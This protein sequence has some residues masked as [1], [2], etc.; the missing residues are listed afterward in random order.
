MGCLEVM[1]A[2]GHG[3][4]DL[5]LILVDSSFHPLWRTSPAF[6]CQIMPKAEGGLSLPLEGLHMCDLGNAGRERV[7]SSCQI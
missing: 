2:A 1:S 3:D 7:K 4:T 5:A 6:V